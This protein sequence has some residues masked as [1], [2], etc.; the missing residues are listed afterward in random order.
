ME[1]NLKRAIDTGLSRLQTTERERAALLQNALEGKK[2]R[3]KISAALIFAM[4]LILAV[5]TAL[6]YTLSRGYFEEVAVIESGHGA[7]E[8]WSLDEKLRLLALMK[9]YGVSANSEALDALLAG[10][11]ADDERERRID[12]WIAEVYGVDDRIDVVTLESILQK[13]LGDFEDWPMEQKAWYSQMLQASGLMGGDDDV[14]RMPDAAA[15][16][17]EEATA[18]ARKEILEAYGLDEES[19]NGYP[20]RWEYKTHVSDTDFSM[21]HY[22]IRFSSASGEGPEY[23]CAVSGDGRVLGSGDIEGLLSPR[24]QRAWDERLQNEEDFE[25]RAVF[26][27][28]AQEHGLTGL[29]FRN[30]TLEDKKAVT[31]LVRPVARENIASNPHYADEAYRFFATHRYGL[32]DGGALSEKEAYAIAYAALSEKLDVDAEIRANLDY[33]VFYD[34]T[35]AER[36]LWKFIFHAQKTSEG[37]DRMKALGVDPLLCYR[38]VMDAAAGSVTEAFA[39]DPSDGLNGTAEGAARER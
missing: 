25:A 13:E 30:W 32:P 18:I 7:Y 16:T 2:V 1:N 34:I 6:A 29:L 20:A 19:L 15:I 3:K 38:V 24:E 12:R 26:A 33:G 9:E 28:Y 36:P 23:S 22:E 11:L 35:D 10:G 21:L 5:V 17:P 37:W 31:D 8:D 4:V 39:F 14:F 27:G